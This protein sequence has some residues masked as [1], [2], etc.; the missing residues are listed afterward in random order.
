[1]RPSIH[2]RPLRTGTLPA[3]SST[4]SPLERTLEAFATQ[5]AAPRGLVAARRHRRGPRAR[6]ARVAACCAGAWP[7]GGVEV[8]R[9]RLRP[10]RPSRSRRWPSSGARASPAQG[11]ATPFVDLAIASSPRSRS[12]ASPSTC[13]ATSCRKARSCA[14][15]SAPSPSRSGP[16]WRC[17]SRASSRTCGMR[18]TRLLHRRQ[19]AHLAPARHRRASSPWRSRSRSR[20]GSRALIEGRVLAAERVELST[21]V[22]IAKLVRAVAFR[23]R[24]WWRCRSWASTS[25]RS[26]SSAA[27]SASGWASACRRSP[28]TT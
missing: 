3:R 27:R 18:S 2:R 4:M 26:R 12:S 22:V 21:R 11:P 6:L 13:C 24:S 15:R 25:P 7:R 8:R 16:A 23:S 10:R 14:A 9:R 17:T 28:A 1:M 20:C 19:A 5:A